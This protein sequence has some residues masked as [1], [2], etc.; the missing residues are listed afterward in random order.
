MIAVLRKEFR[1][2]GVAANGKELLDLLKNQQPDAI[3]IDLQMPC[4]DGLS[5]AKQIA[6]QYPKWKLVI[7]SGYYENEIETE[8]RQAGVKGYLTKDTESVF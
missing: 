1:I 2:L 7:L 6:I 5:A 8:L 3:L 4:M